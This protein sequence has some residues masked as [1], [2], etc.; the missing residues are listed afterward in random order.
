MSSATQTQPWDVHRP[1]RAEG[2]NF[3]VTGGNAG[4]GYFVAEQLAGTGATVVLGIRDTAKAEAAMASIRSR[5]PGAQVRHL[6]VDLADLTSLKTS[7]DALELD[8][9][10]AVVYNAGV[11]LD[12]SQRRETQRLVSRQLLALPEP[13]CECYAPTV[14][15]LACHARLHDRKDLADKALDRPSKRRRVR[16][17]Q[18]ECGSATR[19]RS[20]S[21]S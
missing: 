9:L 1:P 17:P 8:S 18:P 2:R 11:L 15:K 6:R 21:N 20:A 16:L 5:V 3:L 19:S 13:E 10:D 12:Q 4:I 7:V 14:P